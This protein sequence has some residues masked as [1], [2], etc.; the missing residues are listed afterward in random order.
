M[1]YFIEPSKQPSGLGYL[2]SIYE[3]TEAPR[4]QMPG[5]RAVE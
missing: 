4:T 5:L 3:E 2:N 1:H